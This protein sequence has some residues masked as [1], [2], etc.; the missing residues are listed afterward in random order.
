MLTGETGKRNVLMLP[1]TEKMSNISVKYL[2]IGP[3]GTVIST[4]IEILN[5]SL[6]VAVKFVAGDVPLAFIILRLKIYLLFFA[7][8]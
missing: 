2:G 3:L 7:R 4:N 8:M 5:F 6:T 1:N